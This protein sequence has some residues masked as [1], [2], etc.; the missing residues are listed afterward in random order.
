ML[1]EWRF[2]LNTNVLTPTWEKRRLGIFDKVSVD[3]FEVDDFQCLKFTFSWKYSLKKLG[4]NP[5]G[6][7]G[8]ILRGIV[9][10][11]FLKWHQVTFTVNVN[12]T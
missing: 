4:A 7:G 8:H 1:H 3:K 2:Q 10:K 5:Y 9:L 11:G 6:E 12:I